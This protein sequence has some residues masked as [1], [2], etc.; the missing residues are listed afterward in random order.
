MSSDREGRRELIEAVMSAVRANADQTDRLDQ[1]AAAQFG[2]N[3]TD[4]RGLELL[5]RLGP[6]TANQLA[7]KLGMTTGGVTT[8][9]DR[10]EHAGYARRRQDSEDRRRVLVQATK[11]AAVRESEIFG[12]LIDGTARALSSFPDSELATI[13]RFMR[14]LGELMAVHCDRLAAAPGDRKRPPPATDPDRLHRLA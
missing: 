13:E 12:T 1:L 10:L 2:L 14:R 3:R 8:V 5:R 7:I 4:G 11:L 6:M 9:I